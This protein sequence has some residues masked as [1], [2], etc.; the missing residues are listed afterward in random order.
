MGGP[1]PPLH[2]EIRELQAISVQ[3]RLEFILDVGSD[4]IS[5]QE[6]IY[7]TLP[8]VDWTRK[9]VEYN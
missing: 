4:K 3:S 7:M 9:L 6:S 8:Y 1:Q 2:E 5:Q